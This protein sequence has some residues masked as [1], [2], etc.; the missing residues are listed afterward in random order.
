M[1]K[2]NV[3]LRIPLYGLLI[4][5]FGLNACTA[6]STTQATDTAQP[7]AATPTERTPP[8]AQATQMPP[9]PLPTQK[10]TATAVEL[11]EV[12]PGLKSLPDLEGLK[13][14]FNQDAS[15]ARLVLLLSMGC[16]SCLAAGQWI[17]T[18]LLEP[19]PDLQIRVYA[20][21]LPTVSEDLLPVGKNP[22]WDSQ[23]LE[24]PRVIHLWDPER[25]ASSWFAEN[26]KYQGPQRSVLSRTVDGLIWGKAIWDTYFLF[27][28]QAE[29][30]QEPSNL[31]S[32]G[33]PILEHREEIRQSLGIARP[34]Q[35]VQG[36]QI[37]YQI[38]PSDS[39]ISYGVH[40]V[41]A[42]KDFNYAIG[43]TNV[44]SGRIH[45][46]TQDPS[47]SEVEPITV[48]ISQ[49]QSDNY[50]RDD[51]IRNEFLES[52][53]FPQA[54]F[55]PAQLIGLPG[56]YDPGE[57]LKF[58]ILGD[59]EVRDI[60][61]PTTFTVTARLENGLLVGSATSQVRMS[62]F[63]FQPPAIGAGLIKASDPVDL[64]FDFVAIPVS[65]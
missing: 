49:L 53:K 5:A 9:T 14:L 24:D 37:T 7:E 38:D 1:F 48:D 2:F 29:W 13:M 63:D 62:D 30:D 39:V 58:E 46:D 16:P 12:E 56:E 32:S 15:Q 35:E 21:W 60:Q 11:P 8:T 19:D 64:K 20:V 43:F 17:E 55:T 25:V 6:G 40:E 34:S 61:V 41:F 26:V 65:P 59:L 31:L 27:G 28:P 18:N 51:R 22:K 42:G 47:A 3:A 4:L 23:I 52:A 57:T 33:Y 45:L 36:E 10:P 44:I 50:L 54:V